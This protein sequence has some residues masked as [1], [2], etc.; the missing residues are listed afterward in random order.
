MKIKANKYKKT[1]KIN[2]F[3]NRKNNK[4]INKI[5]KTQK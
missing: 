3:I 5:N 4:I 1:K 2:I